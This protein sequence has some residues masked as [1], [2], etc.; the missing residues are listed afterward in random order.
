M[1]LR[2]SGK[3]DQYVHQECVKAYAMVEQMLARRRKDSQGRPSMADEREAEEIVLAQFL[4]FPEEARPDRP[5]P[6]DDLP[7]G[8]MQGSRA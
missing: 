7:H 5:E 2:R 1:E 3:L 4:E 8:R 6:P